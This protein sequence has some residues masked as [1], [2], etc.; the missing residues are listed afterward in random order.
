MKLPNKNL[1]NKILLKGYGFTKGILIMF[2]KMDL[3]RSKQ[4]G[5][6]KTGVTWE[7]RH[8]G[9]II[10]LTLD[11]KTVLGVC[12]PSTVQAREG[13]NLH[14]EDRQVRGVYWEACSEA[15]SSRAEGRKVG[16]R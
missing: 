12:V 10:F 1:F 13:Q 14:A 8:C 2:T 3:R 6:E 5:C 7:Q 11:I 15:S 16:R 4:I 9:R